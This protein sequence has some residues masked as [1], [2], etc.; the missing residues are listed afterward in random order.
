MTHAMSVI[1]NCINRIKSEVKCKI[2]K[3]KKRDTAESKLS[4][5]KSVPA[6]TAL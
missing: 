2:S 1:N 5:S 6:K 3:N 4:K